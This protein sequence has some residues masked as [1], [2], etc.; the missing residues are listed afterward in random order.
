V[1]CMRHTHARPAAG[2]ALF[3]LH[4]GIRSAAGRDAGGRWE[5]AAHLCDV[6]PGHAGAVGQGQ[7]VVATPVGRPRS[8]HEAGCQAAAGMGCVTRP[9]WLCPGPHLTVKG[10]RK[11]RSTS[12]Q[13]NTP[14]TMSIRKLR[15]G[16]RRSRVRQSTGEVRRAGAS[17]RGMH[18]WRHH[19]TA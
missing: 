13:K 15:V 5:P 11:W 7:R 2:S 14:M 6:D 19:T 1:H 17:N 10:Y 18:A 3:G 8:R 9:G 12:T 16:E 4:A